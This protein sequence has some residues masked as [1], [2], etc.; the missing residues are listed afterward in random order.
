[1]RIYISA[2]IEGVAGVVSRQNTAPQ[3]FEY[4][5]ACRWMTEEVLAV[6]A[7]AEAA[8]AATFVVSDSHGNGQNLLPDSFGPNTELVRS[9]P[10]P[11]GMME[12]IDRGGFQAA[13]LIGYHASVSSVA[14]TLAHSFSTAGI[15][16]IAVNGAPASELHLSAA[17]A[18]H[19]GVPVAL[20]S[21]DDAFVE[22]ARSVLG[23]VEAV[24]TKR[25]LGWHSA[26]TLTPAAARRRLAEAAERAFAWPEVRPPFRIDG[27]VTL[28]V[29]FVSRRA[30]ESLAFLRGME[31]TG[32][33]AVRFVA[34]DI[35]DATRFVSFLLFFRL[36]EQ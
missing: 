22:E 14:G 32:A 16:G 24:V 11:L 1:M 30:A 18:G 25:S 8:G 33:R 20:V 13:A 5:S 34:T 15:A 7:G 12:G 26:Q 10:R 6:I 29:E 17:V 28:D 3:G 35:L 27:P 4:A 9:W 21:G 19:F 31:R 23:D 2:D 36:T